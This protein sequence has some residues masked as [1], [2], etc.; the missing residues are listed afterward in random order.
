MFTHTHTDWWYY[1]EKIEQGKVAKCK[2]CDWTKDR[3]KDKS[4]NGLKYHLQHIKISVA[5][6]PQVS[7]RSMWIEN[8]KKLLFIHENLPL[9]GFDNY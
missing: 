4:T 7:K 9:I 3:S 1:F 2:H 8:L 5:A 6:C